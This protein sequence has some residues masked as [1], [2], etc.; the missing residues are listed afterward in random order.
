MKAREVVVPGLEYCQ[1]AMGQ[2]QSQYEVLPALR[3]QTNE[4]TIMARFELTD[5][6]RADIAAG[7]AIVFEQHTFGKPLQPVQLSTVVGE[8]NA[9]EVKKNY[10][11]PSS[12]EHTTAMLATFLQFHYPTEVERFGKAGHQAPEAAIYILQKFLDAGIPVPE[13]IIEGE[14]E[15]TDEDKSVLLDPEPEEGGTLPADPVIQ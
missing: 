10:D 2:G 12:A 14:A 7:G 3:S 8:L 15:E 6:E 1:L 11:L 13:P 9:D 4:S 5:A